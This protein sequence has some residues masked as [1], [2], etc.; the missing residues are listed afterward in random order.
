MDSPGLIFF[1][2]INI[3]E[4]NNID[5][6]RE[7][8]EHVAHDPNYKDISYRDRI[9]TVTVDGKRNYLHPKIPKGKFITWRNIVGLVLLTLLFVL[10]LIKVNGDP[11]VLLDVTNRKFILFGAIFSP[12]DTFVMLLLMLSFILFV[13]LFTVTFGRIWCGW[14]CPQTI[15]LEIV[16][17]RVEKWIEG[18]PHKQKKLDNMPWNGEKIAKRLT[19]WIVFYALSFAFVNAML[20]FFMSFDRWLEYMMDIGN[21][22]SWLALILLFTSIFFGIYTWFRE[23]ICIIACPY[24]RMQ[25]V[26]IDPSTIVISYD[27]LRGEPRGAQ[28]KGSTRET[29]GLGDCIDCHACVDVCPTGIDI[30]NG[31]QL[32]CVNCTACIDACDNIMENVGKPKGL[33]RYA[34]EKEIRTG[35]KVGWSPRIIAYSLVLM[36]ILIFAGFTLFNRSEVSAVILRTPGVI[37]QKAGPDSLINLYNVKMVNKTRHEKHL[38]IKLVDHKGRVT[39]VGGDIVLLPEEKKEAIMFVKIANKDIESENIILTLSVLLDGKE[40]DHPTVT[41]MSPKK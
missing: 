21:H 2:F 18:S 17:R 4:E 37:Y 13:V 34:S 7:Q 33:I 1:F 3:M 9:S 12:Q 31:T 5:K 15:F 28:K 38:D 19:K 16:F 25:S 36:V 27:Y 41:F 30:R 32:E 40:M 26:L 14:L 23:Q 29:T 24:G 39:I 8:R 11:F 10:P 20:W 22:G 6:I 35:K